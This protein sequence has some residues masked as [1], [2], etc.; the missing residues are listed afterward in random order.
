MSF[1]ISTCENQRPQFSW[2][3]LGFAVRWLAYH[4]STGLVVVS[5]PRL[6]SPFVCG[7]PTG[8]S[9][10]L[11]P[12]KVELPKGLTVLWVHLGHS[13]SYVGGVAFE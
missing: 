13:M 1:G 4:A 8:F 6:G 10:S 3:R 5:I 7:F 12:H 11:F 9:H 2:T